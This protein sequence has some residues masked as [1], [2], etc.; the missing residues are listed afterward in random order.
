VVGRDDIARHISAFDI[1]LLPGVTPYSSPLKLF[2][3]LYLGRAIAAPDMPNIREI[4]TPDGN[5]LLFDGADGAMERALLALCQ[6]AGLRRRLGEAAGRTVA[7]KSL[8]WDNNAERV[9]ALAQSLLSS[10]A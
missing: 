2:E 8:T 3:Y 10:R 9:V 6:D 7:E 4:L 5:A 1:A